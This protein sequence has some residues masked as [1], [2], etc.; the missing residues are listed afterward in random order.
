MDP[1]QDLPLKD[2]HL[3]DPVSWWPPA[4]G[5]WLSVLAVF[6]IAYLLYKLV[7]KIR[8]PVLRKSAKAEIEKVIADYI[9]SHDKLKLLHDVST[10]IRRI[11]ISYLQRNKVA[12]ISGK[13][14][15]QE[16]NKLSTE[17]VFSDQVIAILEMATY[18]KHPDLDDKDIDA[19]IQETRGWVNSLARN[20]SN[21]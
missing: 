18:Q 20:S 2:I 11:G 1:A 9:Q 4:M 19:V 5:W 8:Q 14:W 12:G 21:V 13:A 10:A 3:P 17:A 16:L 6:L 15:Y 7:K